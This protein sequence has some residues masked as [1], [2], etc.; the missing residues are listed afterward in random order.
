VLCY[1]TVAMN[2]IQL[3]AYERSGESV[4]KRS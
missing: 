3:G 2:Y 1:G 4:S